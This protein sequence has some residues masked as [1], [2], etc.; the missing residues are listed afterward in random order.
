MQLYLDADNY[1][2]KIRVYFLKYFRKGHIWENLSKKG[3]KNK[4]DGAAAHAC[5]LQIV[6]GCLM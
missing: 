2:A 3:L 1:G 5:L 6:I 4:K